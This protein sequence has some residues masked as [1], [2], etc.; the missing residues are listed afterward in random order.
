MAPGGS[1]AAGPDNNIISTATGGGYASSAGTSMAVPQVSGAVALLL[2]QGLSPSAAVSKL[3]AT[4]DR[5]PCGAGCQGRLNVGVAAGPPPAPPTGEG[6]AAAAA[7]VED[8]TPPTSRGA[9][10]PPDTTVAPSRR[11]RPPARPRRGPGRPGGAGRPGGRRRRAPVAPP[12]LDPLLVAAVAV[13]LVL[14]V[15]R[16]GGR[17]VGPPPL[18]H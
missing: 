15:G 2:A 5:V 3:L 14:A 17:G 8:T 7:A 1:G 11:R 16:V 6:P 4:L 12:E 18:D 9:D 13:G 10:A